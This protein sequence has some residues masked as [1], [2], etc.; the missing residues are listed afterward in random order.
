MAQVKPVKIDTDGV[1]VETTPTADD[2][3]FASYTVQGG[4]PVLNANLDMNNGNIS[5]AG[6]LA[7]TDPATDGITRTDGTHAA[8][9]I[10]MQDAENV[11]AVG[12]AV[13]F[14]AIAD[15]ADQVDALRVPAL[16]GAPTATPTD[17]GEGYLV[18]DSTNKDLYAWNGSAWDN[19]NI[20]E[21]AERVCN[22]YTATSTLAV[23]EIVY[24]DGADS[25]DKA[26][27]S[28][29]GAAS[30]VMGMAGEAITAAAAGRICSDGVVTGL[31]G[32]TAGARYFG[33]P[34]V[35]G[36]IT[37]T[38][39]TGAGNTIVQIGYAK[40]TTAIHLHIEQLGRIS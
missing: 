24:I 19:L 17:G 40:S 11:I 16:A 29:A 23:G 28:A 4:G 13:L 15:D 5:D 31:T 38:R 27:V 37:T 1:L 9:D 8:D 6:D 35:A 34:A 32:L 21:E 33:N 2:V 25:V 30:Q 20:V 7:F 26:D 3:T 14:P 12:A 18:W 10:M 22:Q 39:P 36:G